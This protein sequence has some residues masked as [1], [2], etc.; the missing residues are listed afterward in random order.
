L[1]SVAPGAI[2]APCRRL[3]LRSPP[4]SSRN[5][6]ATGTADE[7]ADLPAPVV[8]DEAAADRGDSGGAG[9]VRSDAQFRPEPA[10]S[11]QHRLVGDQDDVIDVALND[12]EN[13]RIGAPAGHC[14]Y[15][16]GYFWKAYQFPRGQA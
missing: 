8:V 16:T 12:V 1:H 10:R 3:R 11:R 2:C 6:F 4:L 15:G 9:E 13:R 5:P 7:R 14:R